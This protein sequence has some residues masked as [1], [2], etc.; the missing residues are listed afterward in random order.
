MT[1]RF[2]RLAA[3]LLITALASGA[4]HISA[5]PVA[6][7]DGPQ[8]VSLANAKRASVGK[9]PVSYSA[10]LEQISH[11]R[12]LT[13][14][15]NVVL[16]H[17]M[18]YVLARLKAVGACITGWGEII[19]WERGYPTYDPARTIESSQGCSDSAERVDRAKC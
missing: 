4:A 3:V 2:A 7:V 6:A 8:Y 16:E 14:A 13:M 5:P 12:A 1:P 10:L 17:D 19:A 18:A 9:G 11:E 15:R